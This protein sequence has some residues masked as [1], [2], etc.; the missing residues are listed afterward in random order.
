VTVDT[1]WRFGGGPDDYARHPT[2]LEL[3]PGIPLKVLDVDTGDEITDLVDAT[4]TPVT[5]VYSGDDG[6]F[7][8]RAPATAVDIA[9]PDGEGERLW[10]VLSK[11][12]LRTGLGA[13]TGAAGGLRT[14][15]P[16]LTT[17]TAQDNSPR[18]QAVLNGLANTANYD[19][20]HR[21]DVEGPFGAPV[22]CNSPINIETDRVDLNFVSSIDAGPLFQI[23]IQGLTAELPESGKPILEA[24]YTAG[25]LDLVVNDASLFGAGD[26]IVV[27]GARGATGDPIDGQKA[28]AYVDSVDLGTNTITLTEGLDEDFLAVNANPDSPPGTSPES[29]VTKVVAGNL[30]VDAAR[31]SRTVTVHDTAP[32]AAGDTVQVMDDSR[33]TRS[34]TG[35]EEKDNFTAR[36]MNTVAEVVSSTQLRLVHPLHHPI[37]TAKLGKVILVNPIR[38]SKVTNARVRWTAMSEVQTAFEMRYTVSCRFVECEVTGTGTG[39]AGRATKSWLGQ[40]FRIADSLYGA[41]V[42]CRASRPAVSGGGQGYGFTI[43]GSNQCKIINCW[44]SGLRHTTLLFNS[45]SGNLITGCIGEDTLLSDWDLHGCACFDNTF[46]NLKSIGGQSL[47]SNGDSNRA[48]V[49]V[50]NTAHQDGDAYNTFDGVEVFGFYDGAAVDFV[51]SSHHNEVRNVTATHC[52]TGVRARPTPSSVTPLYITDNIVSGL[53]TRDVTNVLDVNGLTDVV[54]KRLVIEGGK[55]IGVTTHLRPQNAERVE[56]RRCDWIDPATAAGTYAVYATNVSGLAVR[57]CDLSRSQRGVKLDTCPNSR[58]TSNVMHD[59]GQT[60]VIDDDGGN[61]G[62]V[63]RR[64]DIAGFT[65][66]AVNNGASF[67]ADLT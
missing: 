56:L 18:I 7:D 49:R 48:A 32:F 13:T 1:M 8:F 28:Y 38:G 62:S 26:Y 14:T 23:R 10:R 45:A 30:T 52:L 12:A 25:D 64:N 19:H 2:E 63:F 3:L 11:D 9:V 44:G 42:R 46:R 59:F 5:Q 58:I 20:S 67:T 35:L 60:Q 57:Q 47:A 40:A 17:G 21:V 36:E 61:T 50:G 16:G 37:T 34:T 43:Y 4:G 66:T 53:T 22:Y 65:A 31:N 51:A 33:T 15:V 55:F 6:T 41:T 54:V 24:D 39:T 29:Q 27:R